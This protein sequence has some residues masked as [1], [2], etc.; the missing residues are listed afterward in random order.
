MAAR[1]SST[2]SSR[3]SQ[4]CRRRDRPTRGASANGSGAGRA[5]LRLTA[6]W[7]AL[8]SLA[9]GAAANV[10]IVRA[11]GPNARRL[12]VGAILA[13]YSRFTLG[14]GDSVPVPP[15]YGTRIFRGPGA[16]S[17]AD[18]IRPAPAGR[19]PPRRP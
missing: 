10:I 9:A 5:M 14:P 19:P 8:L 11:N 16:F 4:T 15:P 12:G 7:A 13:D 17:A 2:S 6:G 3:A 1:A 18:P